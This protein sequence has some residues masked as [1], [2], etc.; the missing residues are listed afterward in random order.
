MDIL[1]DED[2]DVLFTNGESSV[3]SIGAEDLAQRL[4]IRLRTFLG[5]YFMDNTLGVDWFGRVFGKNRSKT[6]V[7]ALLQEEILKERDALQI[8]NYSSSIGTDRTFTCTFSVRTEDGAV[9]NT[10]TITPPL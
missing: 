7:D 1:L 8:T 3:T 6:A 4:Q 5:E 2:G 9:A 10:F